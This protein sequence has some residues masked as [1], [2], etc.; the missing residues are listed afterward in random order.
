MAVR[1]YKRE[2]SWRKRPD[3]RQVQGEWQIETDIYGAG[4]S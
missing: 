1:P 4:D 3:I 2:A